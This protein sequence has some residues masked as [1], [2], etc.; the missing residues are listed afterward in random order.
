MVS[1]VRG[2]EHVGVKPSEEGNNAHKK[3]VQELGLENVAMTEFM[4]GIDEKVGLDA[5]ETGE[6]CCCGGKAV[7][8]TGKGERQR[9]RGGKHGQPRDG[10]QEALR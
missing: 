1:Q 10:L 7:R 2:E 9:G 8:G 4:H 6:K 3:S 5:V